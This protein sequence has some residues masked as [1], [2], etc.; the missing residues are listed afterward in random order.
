MPVDDTDESRN[1]EVVIEPKALFGD[2]SGGEASSAEN[3]GSSI[4][5][6]E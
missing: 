5:D 2:N 6:G 4:A 3:D 1:D